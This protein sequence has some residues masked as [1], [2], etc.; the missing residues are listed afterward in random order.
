M[1]DDPISESQTPALTDAHLDWAAR[2]CGID[3]RAGVISQAAPGGKEAPGKPQPSKPAATGNGAEPGGTSLDPAFDDAVKKADWPKAAQCLDAHAE[4]DI[5]K[6]LAPLSKAD[7]AKLHQ[8]A[9]DEPAL[10][11]NSTAALATAQVERPILAGGQAKRA[12]K[13]VGKMSSREK[14]KYQEMLDHAGAEQKQYIT[15]GLAAGHSV[16]ELERFA[17]KI[18]GKDA[19]WMQDNLSLTGNSEGKGVKQQWHMSCNAT[20][21]EAVRAEFDPVYALKMHEDNPNLTEADGLDGKKLN[22]KL[23][24]DQKAMLESKY[25][26][27]QGKFKGGRARPRDNDPLQQGRWADDLLNKS[28][29]MTGFTFET[30]K[31]G[32]DATL[33]EG[34]ASIEK[35]LDDG[36]P[37]PIVIGNSTTDAAGNKQNS[38][39]HYV[40]VTG[41][42]PGPPRYYTIHDP[43]EGKTYTRSEDQLKT[44]QLDIANANEIAA[45]EKPVAVPEKKSGK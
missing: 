4:A 33:D 29:K 32:E 15:K 3:L 1:E 24:K 26:G 6:L 28:K 40:V 23:A 20:S 43:W 14:K 10:G 19:K 36:V 34:I 17:K 12:E 5:R 27:S 7:I 31:I 35:N 38:Y 2:F 25:D 22:P 37:V 8:A 45:L 44:G 16:G 30:Q 21:V 42:D 39:Q 11:Q 18:A 13:L 9:V 41:T